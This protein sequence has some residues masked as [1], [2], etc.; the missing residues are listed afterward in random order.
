MKLKSKDLISKYNL[1]Y[2]TLKEMRESNKISYE[3]KG[4][5]YIYN[6]SEELENTFLNIK[7]VTDSTIS[8]GFDNIEYQLD[9]TNLEIPDA[10]SYIFN[11]N[12]N[13]KE[14]IRRGYELRD[15]YIQIFRRVSERPKVSSSIDEIVNEI[16][17]PFDDG[18]IV[19]IEFTNNKSLG[20][21]TKKTLLDEFNTICNVI[22]ISDNFD[23][24]VREWYIDG[25]LGL[26][27][28]YDNDIKKGIL[29]ILK[30]NPIGLRRTEQSGRK[31]YQYTNSYYDVNNV[32]KSDKSLYMEEQ[33]IQIDSGNW[34]SER[35]FQTSYLKTALKAINDLSHIE[36]SIIK[37]RITRAVE[38]NIWN[39]D[40]GTM[41]RNKAV[42]HIN[43]VSND[44]KSNLKYNTE[45]GEVNVDV[46]EG[47]TSDW[48]FPSRNGKQKT[49]VNTIGGNSDF[50]S[51]LEYLQYFRR[52]LYEAL[53]IPVGRLDGDSSLDYSGQ[54]ILREEI[55]F[56]KFVE[57]LKRQLT[58]LF[59]ELLKRQVIR[60]G[61]IV[62]DEWNKISNDVKF[63]WNNSNPII[64]NAKLENIKSRMET[65]SELK[66]SKIIGKI[67]SIQYAVS[68][69][70][71]MT[72][73]DFEEQQK[74]ILEEK[75][76][77]KSFYEDEEE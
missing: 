15:Y 34:D 10:S 8:S 71:D 16:N 29:S 35:A 56:N 31:Y 27:V 18:D 58:T 13:K 6:I 65:F 50:I 19:K 47:I 9:S 3:K 57:K 53:K 61:I 14:L 20:E 41:A 38:R 17:V 70:L 63:K 67:V 51:K 59:K 62:E 37:Y 39:V 21:N 54:D 73:E 44:V 66:E 45:T 69:I 49:E 7:P 55:K 52:E 32:N 1:A 74:L 11:G 42:Q 36:N 24:L 4:N 68:H 75:K 26:E 64:E 12:R 22:N 76:K 25:T 40:V 72:E 46:T 5:S 43:T 30:L 23:N 77:Y 33:I 60:K 48:I 28:V 2:S